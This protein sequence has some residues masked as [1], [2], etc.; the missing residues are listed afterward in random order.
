MALVES[1]SVVWIASRWNRRNGESRCA[2]RVI[3]GGAVGA[4]SSAV[5]ADGRS[6]VRFLDTARS[7]PTVRSVRGTIEDETQLTLSNL[8]ATVEAAG[9]REGRCRAM[10]DA[11]S[12]IGNFGRFD[13]A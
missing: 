3:A 5:V 2:E 11:S 9:G 7:N 10:P 12:H 4:Y 8:M 6:G 1:A 13:A